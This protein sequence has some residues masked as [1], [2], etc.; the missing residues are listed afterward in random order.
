M[1]DFATLWKGRERMTQAFQEG[2]KVRYTMDGSIWF[3][4]RRNGERGECYQKGADGKI[5]KQAS[6][7]LSQL[8]KIADA[9]G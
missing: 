4:L 3:F 8:E 1:Q 5:I 7:R 2:D 9:A 6:F